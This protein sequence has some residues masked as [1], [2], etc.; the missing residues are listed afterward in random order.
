M[1]ATATTTANTDVTVIF[2]EVGFG[3]GGLDDPR[4]SEADA[5][6]LVSAALDL[7]VT[8]FDTA[9]SY[10]ASEERLGRALR[11]AR[12]RAVVFTKG[13][14]GVEGAADWTGPAVTKGIEEAIVRLGREPLD[15]FLLHSCDLQ[16]LERGDVPL[17][18]VRAREAGKV[19][20]TG[21]S[22]EGAAL[23][24]AAA[25]RETFS[26]LE[27]SLSP[28]D[29]ANL[30]LISRAAQGDFCVLA[31]RP[32]ANAPWRFATRPDRE[33][34]A[35]YW[36]RLRALGFDPAPLAWD[37]LA[38]RFTA[39]QPGVTTA[40]VGT[41]RIEH[42]ASAV[43]AVRAGALPVDVSE[44]LRGAFAARGRGWPGLV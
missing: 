28:L 6:R 15:G 3:A 1:V 2:S 9:R 26:V 30:E 20:L 36:D 18:L 12:D 34:I 23:A 16:T 17:A 33:D 38:L 27:C 11:G 14:Y 35:V 40:L 42:L 7:G 10:G 4:L 24:W 37:E 32:L 29:Q 19:R 21:Y 8:V 13:G 43:A 5:G 41:T 25:R 44:R 39:F 22:G 31:K